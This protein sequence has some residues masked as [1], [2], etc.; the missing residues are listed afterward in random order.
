M[1]VMTEAAKFARDWLTCC[2][3]PAKEVSTVSTSLL[4]RFNMRPVD[5][6]VNADICTLFE[7]SLTLRRD[8]M[9]AH[10]G[11]N[12]S[13]E[14]PSEEGPRRAKSSS[15]LRDDTGN[16]H[17]SRTKGNCGVYP[18]VEEGMVLRTRPVDG[19]QPRHCDTIVV[20]MRKVSGGVSM[21]QRDFVLGSQERRDHI[22]GRAVAAAPIGFS[23]D[24]RPCISQGRSR[25]R[26]AAP[27]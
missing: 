13:C 23:P 24:L 22:W 6:T 21:V 25:E 4:K 20:V 7:E 12:D 14:K 3:E 27:P 11:T 17:Q 9:P 15:V 5:D 19:G 1:T 8:I 16:V 18:N 2:R 10:S 26:R